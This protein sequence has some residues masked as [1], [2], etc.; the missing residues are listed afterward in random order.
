VL[1]VL[2]GLLQFLPLVEDLAVDAIFL[3]H[4]LSEG[5]VSGF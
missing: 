1:A 4:G 5:M 3:G 2:V